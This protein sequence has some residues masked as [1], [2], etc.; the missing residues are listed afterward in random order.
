MPADEVTIDTNVFVHL[1]NPQN[2]RGNH[3]DKLLGSLVERRF[4]LC[5]DDQERI[6]GEYRIHII[7]LFKK[8]DD[9]GLRVFWLR[10]FLLDANKKIVAVEHADQLMTSIRRAIYRAERSD[11]VFVYVA[12]TTDTILIS[13]NPRHITDHRQ[14]LRKSARR[15]G[16]KTTD[17]VDSEQ[18][19]DTFGC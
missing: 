11:H 1:F 12:I 10:Y 3:I 6:L 4:G 16:S 14:V 2:N 8:A 17:F 18:A 7:P 15:H 5:I 19:V 13:N 9:E